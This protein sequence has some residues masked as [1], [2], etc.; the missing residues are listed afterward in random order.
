MISNEFRAGSVAGSG[1]VLSSPGGGGGGVVVPVSIVAQ[2]PSVVVAG[3][4]TGTG[5]DGAVVPGT[6]SRFPMLICSIVLSTQL[7]CTQQQQQQQHWQ[8]R[9]S[10]MS[11][12]RRTAHGRHTRRH[13]TQLLSTV[14]NL[15]ATSD[16]RPYPGGGGDL[17]DHLERA[18]GKLT[19]HNVLFTFTYV[20]IDARA[21]TDRPTVNKTRTADQMLRHEM[22]HQHQHQQQQQHSR[23]PH[24]RRHQH[25]A[26]ASRADQ[27]K[28][29]AATT[30]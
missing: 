17:Q 19:Q 5:T 24:N 9:R 23:R 10:S 14:A 13:T 6:N 22:R 29:A 12:G 2:Q 30:D 7:A 8:C 11:V 18:G 21:P 1:S 3:A 15:S 26:P 25:D 4:G 20:V 28:W 27:Q 16:V